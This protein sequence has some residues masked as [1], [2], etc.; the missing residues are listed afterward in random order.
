MGFKKDLHEVHLEKG[1]KLLESIK[2]ER[3]G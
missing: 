3:N 2:G 1:R